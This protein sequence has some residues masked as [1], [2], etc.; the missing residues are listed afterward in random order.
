[1][2][3]RRS[4]SI[5][6]GLLA[7]LALCVVCVLAKMTTDRIEQ[8]KAEAPP[9]VTPRYNELG[10]PY[11]QVLSS[12]PVEVQP[13]YLI[14]SNRILR[15][16]HYVP[17][18]V[19][20][21]V[22]A[23]NLFFSVVPAGVN[24]HLIMAPWYIAMEPDFSA[25]TDDIHAAIGEVY[26]G[27]VEDVQCLDVCDTL[28]AQR[29]EYI[30][31]RVDE[32][33]TMLGAYYAAREFLTAQG[34]EM[35][36]VEDY[37]IYYNSS[38]AGSYE[39]V[40]DDIKYDEDQLYYLLKGATNWQTVT[41]RVS[42]GVYETHESP[43]IALSRR[44]SIFLGSSVSHSI[45][46]GDGNNGKTLLIIGDNL[47]RSFAPWFTPYYDTVYFIR[48]EN[49]QDGLTGFLSI[50]EDY[51]IQDCLVVESIKSVVDSANN[52]LRRMAGG[53]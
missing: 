2:N 44:Q 13:D 40:A 1:M 30:F 42:S 11:G 50:F 16:Y 41:K 53:G 31:A 25:Y 35:I 26:A 14:F 7:L 5:L 51:A 18:D 38:Y 36:P 27:M 52:N 37:E 20:H 9:M 47:G 43:A 28:F 49:Y 34:I 46:H 45:L 23:L 29:D 22:E 4:L 48:A 33:W 12:E 19:Q 24:K 21:T 15:R 8:A 32:D 39:K 3:K 6:L 17:E 10:L